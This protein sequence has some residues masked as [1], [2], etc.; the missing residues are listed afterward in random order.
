MK[1]N[2]APDHEHERTPLLQGHG[3][4]LSFQSD[5][6]SEILALVMP[7]PHFLETRK[8]RDD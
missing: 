3:Y 7:E 4:F 1:V 5:A 8:N 6:K 2:I